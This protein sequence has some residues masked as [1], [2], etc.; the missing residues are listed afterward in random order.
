MSILS[1]LFSPFAD[2]EHGGDFKKN[3]PF[4]PDFTYNHNHL[5]ERNK[6]TLMV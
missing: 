2:I 6:F 5:V 4:H 3:Y 1:P